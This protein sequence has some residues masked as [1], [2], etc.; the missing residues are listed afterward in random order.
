MDELDSK[1]IQLMMRNA[2]MPVKE[3]AKQV[4]L[5]SP[6]VSSRIHRLEQE[7]VIAG[8]TVVLH[9]PDTPARVEALISVLVDATTRADFLSLVDEEPQV[10]QC[11][12]VTGSYNF[13]VK[14]SCTDIDALEHLLTRM[15]KLGST[16]TQI[17]LNT[18]LDRSLLLD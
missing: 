13:M 3:I 6:A 4:N 7:G 8:Y 2:R 17:I 12:R 11:Y 10:L 18:Q 14:V 5:T 1:I 9:R 16:N 15:Q